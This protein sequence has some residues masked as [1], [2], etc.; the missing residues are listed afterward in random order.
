MKNEMNYEVSYEKALEK[1]LKHNKP[2][3]MMIGQTECPYCNKFE[4]K[5]LIRESVHKIVEKSFI[6]LTVL[7]DKDIYPKKFK[8]KGVPTVLFIDP[9]L[10][11]TFYKSFG[12]KSKRDYKVE[13]KK[14][15]QIYNKDYKN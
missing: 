7:R 15:L 13:L 9:K 14:A 3:M 4:I 5:T 8:D 10:E 1:A 12:Y 2:I 6:P 11:K